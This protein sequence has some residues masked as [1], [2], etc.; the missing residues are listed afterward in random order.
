MKMRIY[1]FIIESSSFIAT[2]TTT[3]LPRSLPYGESETIVS[4]SLQVLAVMS[5]DLIAFVLIFIVA[6]RA[7]SGRR[8]SKQIAFIH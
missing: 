7:R 5:G 1:C 2:E 3:L 6:D 8:M 4:E